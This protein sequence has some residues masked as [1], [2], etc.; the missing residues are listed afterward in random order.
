M[1]LILFHTKLQTYTTLTKQTNCKREL[2]NDIYILILT[3]IWENNATMHVFYE[4]K[5]YLRSIL[6]EFIKRNKRC[7]PSYRPIK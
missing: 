2:I 7:F 4:M 3:K 6:N 5:F 1:F